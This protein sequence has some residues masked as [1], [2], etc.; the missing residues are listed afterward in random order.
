MNESASQFI[1]RRFGPLLIIGVSAVAG[2]YRQPQPVSKPEPVQFNSMVGSSETIAQLR[3]NGPF[4]AEVVGVIVR[5]STNL[6]LEVGLTNQ[7]RLVT[8]IYSVQFR[9]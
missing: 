3:T 5:E 1:K 6:C 2:C 4:R 8:N 7:T 9:D